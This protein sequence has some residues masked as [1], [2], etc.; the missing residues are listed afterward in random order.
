MSLS[1]YI[2]LFKSNCRYRSAPS[3][4]A[5]L[6][7]PPCP[8]AQYWVKGAVELEGKSWSTWPEIE[9]VY[10]L[11]RVRW[12]H[13]ATSLQPEQLG[14]A[15]GRGQAPLGASLALRWSAARWFPQGAGIWRWEPTRRYRSVRMREA[16]QVPTPLCHK[17]PATTLP[18]W[19]V[20]SSPPHRFRNR[21]QNGSLL[22]CPSLF[23]AFRGGCTECMS[24]SWR[25]PHLSLCSCSK[26]LASAFAEWTAA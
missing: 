2:L 3:W 21:V 24:S 18:R 6:A 9:N 7:N 19:R 20:N 1:T 8:L 23:C 22:G 16:A 25:W 5:E 14:C 15:F 26:T 10:K 11:S 4:P 17:R 13:T 12:Q